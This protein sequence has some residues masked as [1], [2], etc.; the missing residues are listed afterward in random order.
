[1]SQA[2][3]QPS[4]LLTLNLE[5]YEIVRQFVSEPT[6]LAECESDSRGN[7]Y[8]VKDETNNPTG[9]YKWRGSAV[10][11]NQLHSAGF[12]G[13]VTA[14]AG[15]H[16]QGV[17]WISGSMGNFAEVFVP[18]GTPHSK[19]DG[20]VRLGAKVHLE[21]NNFDEA[22]EQARL[23]AQL[24]NQPFIH[25]FDDYSVMEG[26]G[27]IANEL[28]A[29]FYEQKLH[30][31]DIVLFVPVGGGGLIGGVSKRIKHLTNGRIKVVGVQVEG[32]D[33]AAVSFGINTKASQ[34][35]FADFSRIY[36]STNKNLNSYYRQK[37]TNPN[38]EVDGTRVN[39]V[40]DYC[41]RSINQYVD[42]FLVVSPKLIGQYYRENEFSQLEPAG[43]LSL[44]GAKA[45]ASLAGSSMLNLVSI[46]SGKNQDPERIQKLLNAV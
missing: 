5:P 38:E 27:T 3:K 39:L 25:P 7:I 23:F 22:T 26:Q 33:S 9:A 32:S 1:M 31:D 45:Y 36:N 14:S 46:A 12:S 19:L 13:V 24:N 2:L 30:H 43:A 16:G 40:G 15:N 37:A 28:V 6:P 44:V 21:G 41:I 34:K 17:A 8:F 29:Q 4:E 18:I 11:L 20:L 35:H 42:E 10:K